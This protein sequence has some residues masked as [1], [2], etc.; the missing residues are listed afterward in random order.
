MSNEEIAEML[1]AEIQRVEQ[2]KKD[3]NP[4]N[5]IVVVHLS[6]D[7]FLKMAYL[8]VGIHGK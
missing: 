3:E 2:N 1:K 4:D 8:F 7:V 6:P 5:R